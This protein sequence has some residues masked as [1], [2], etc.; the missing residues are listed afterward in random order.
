MFTSELSS[1][2]PWKIRQGFQGLNW[3]VT[4][5][6]TQCPFP[7]ASCPTPSYP[8]F[9]SLQSP[10]HPLCSHR[11]CLC[12]RTFLTCP[13][14]LAIFSSVWNGTRFRFAS[15]T[16]EFRE[17]FPCCTDNDINLNFHMFFCFSHGHSQHG[18]ICILPVRLLPNSCKWGNCLMFSLLVIF[19]LVI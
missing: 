17:T 10:N 12:L 9:L 13:F 11:A 16:I 6:L 15:N 4:M 7:H 1:F 8:M 2:L 3:L 5:S 14:N 18:Y 19:F